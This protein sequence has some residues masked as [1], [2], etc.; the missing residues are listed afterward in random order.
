M[1]KNKLFGFTL[2]ELLIVMGIIG[3]LGAVA[4]TFYL[5]EAKRAQVQ[6]VRSQLVLDL[7]DARSKAQRYNC[8]W[9]ITLVNATSYTI[10][11]P[12]L[13]GT[14]TC[15]NTFAT[16]RTMPNGI[17]IFQRTST[18]VSA[19]PS[20]FQIIYQAPYGTLS[21]GSNVDVI[22]VR[23]VGTVVAI[24]PPPA[25]PSPDMTF[26]KVLGVTGKVI[27]SASY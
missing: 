10:V 1:R 6:A 23:R 14:V 15:A 24:S 11:G 3:V 5:R 16:T 2:I 20:N 12:N 13:S 25:P 21:S 7:Q 19:A 27:A 17:E 8:D 18:S 4:L 26:V 9:T 22:E